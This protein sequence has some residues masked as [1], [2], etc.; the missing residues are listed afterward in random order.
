MIKLLHFEFKRFI[1]S[2]RIILII[3]LLLL[4]GLSGVA[5]CHAFYSP[6]QEPKIGLL[7]LFNSYTQ[8]TF[9]VLAFLFARYFARDLED[10][11]M[12]LFVYLGFSKNKIL[13]AKFLLLVIVVL[14]VIDITMAGGYCFYGC[15]DIA[16][17][18]EVLLLLNLCV[19][20]IV[21]C[22]LF[23]SSIFKKA[24]ITAIAMYAYFLI[25][26]VLNLFCFGL[27]NQAD[28]NSITTYVAA[29]TSGII[30]SHPSLSQ[31]SSPF[32][33][34]IDIFSVLINVLWVAIFIIATLIIN[35]KSGR[36]YEI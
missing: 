18:G 4:I 11:S 8:F 23:F 3:F 19:L 24:S 20:S 30:N 2:K 13:F 28:G 9:L 27:A 26:N 5:L 10:G 29:K 1:H 21:S 17:L 16:Y 34:N 25:C 33:E 14:P 36:K 12:I 31:I 7:S 6:L 35:S 22:A 32:V 15:N